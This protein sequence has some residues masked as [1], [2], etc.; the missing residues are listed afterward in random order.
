MKLSIIIINYNT[1]ETTYKCL[2]TLLD[3]YKVDN[4][5]II[6]VDNASTECNPK[7]FQEHFQHIILVQSDKNLGFAGGNNLGLQYAKGKYILLLNSDTILTEDCITP[8]VKTLESE[9]QIG[10]ISP[11]LLNPD[12]S[13]QKNAR[14]TKT[15]SKEL[16][17][18]LRPLIKLLPYKFYSNFFL[19]QYFKGDYDTECDWVCGAFFMTRRDIIDKLPLKK[20]DDRFF[21]YGEDSLWCNQIKVLG[22]KV[23][24]VSKYSLIHVG[25]VSTDKE[26]SVKLNSLIL[27]REVELYRYRRNDTL[28]VI[29]FSLII[30]FKQYLLYS[31]NNKD[32]IFT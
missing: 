13:Y 26:K 12:G 18:F 6:L 21:M 20:L 8:C 32:R 3:Y 1:F 27:D 28:L 14:R 10:V 2:T 15:I 23:L 31:I 16:L 4:S 11:K 9:N 24:F 29:L 30:R 25:N 22:Y 19:N 17:D 7:L 5:E